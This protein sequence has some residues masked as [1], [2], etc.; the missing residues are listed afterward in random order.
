MMMRMMMMMFK[1]NELCTDKSMPA[2]INMTLTTPLELIDD[3]NTPSHFKRDN[4][5]SD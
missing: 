4:V 5:K 1:Y 3:R 2:Y